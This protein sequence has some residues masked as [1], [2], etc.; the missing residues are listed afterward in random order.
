MS[1]TNIA[2]RSQVT[3]FYKYGPVLASSHGHA[4]LAQNV[5]P[6][7][8]SQLSLVRGVVTGS[9]LLLDPGLVIRSKEN[10]NRVCP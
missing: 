9:E 6:G 7:L 5:G 3:K 4:S 1:A 8:T 10:N 2:I